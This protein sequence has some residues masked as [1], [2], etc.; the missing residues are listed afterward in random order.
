MQEKNQ[1]P[2][3]ILSSL[4]LALSIAAPVR[5]ATAQ[6][7]TQPDRAAD[8]ARQAIMGDASAWTTV[9]PLPAVSVEGKTPVIFTDPGKYVFLYSKAVYQAPTEHV[10]VVRMRP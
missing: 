3:H 7:A 1:Y 4:V 9:P 2:K 8:A 5:F 10:M 6:V